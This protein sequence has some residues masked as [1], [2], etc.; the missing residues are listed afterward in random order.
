MGEHEIAR[1]LVDGV[2]QT[3]DVLE[4]SGPGTTPNLA[5]VLA[6]GNDANA[7]Q[8]KNA[9]EGTDPDD[10]ATVSQLS[11]GSRP[12]VSEDGTSGLVQQPDLIE[13]P[14][15]TVDE[16]IAGVARVTL[17]GSQP[18]AMVA[19][20]VAFTEVNGPKT[21]TAELP[22][23]AGATVTDVLAYPIVAAW[24]ALRVELTMGDTLSGADIYF[25]GLVVNTLLSRNYNPD[26][27]HYRSSYTSLGADGSGYQ[28]SGVS[29]DNTSQQDASGIRYVD[30][31]TLTMSVVTTMPAKAITAVD[32]GT[33]TFTI[34]D[35]GSFGV[36]V[37]AFPV[38]NTFTVAGSTGNDGVYTV[39]SATF[40]TDHTDIIVVEAIPDPTIDG[41]ITPAY[42]GATG[43]LVL[44]VRYYTA[45]TIVNA[46]AA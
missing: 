28:D 12:D 20:E 46:I 10:L 44:Q 24:R 34:F 37:N 2:W 42:A 32:Q 36:Y 26:N 40:N 15:A 9:A 21:Y 30:A 17:G 13:F 41:A 43:V 39:V 27:P 4:D 8:I 14:G 16:P 38:G 35:L 31:D 7:E 1:R 45:P 33:K 19:V 22:I 3:I 11:A 25:D 23:P 29:F 6:Q 18:G 5:A